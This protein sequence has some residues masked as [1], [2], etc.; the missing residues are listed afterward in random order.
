MTG[1]VGLPPTRFDYTAPA[2]AVAALGPVH[3][4][5]IGGAGMSGIARICLLYTSRCV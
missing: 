4:I 2:V 3:L 1:P 5:G